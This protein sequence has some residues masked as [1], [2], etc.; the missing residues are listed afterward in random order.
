MD[1]LIA[2][3]LGIPIALI[4]GFYDRRRAPKP[5]ID[6]TKS[7]LRPAT[8]DAATPSQ[9]DVP[10]LTRLVDE[11]PA[12][13]RPV[14]QFVVKNEIS[15]LVSAKDLREKIASGTLMPN[16]PVWTEGAS[17]WKPASD[18]A[19]LAGGSFGEQSGKSSSVGFCMPTVL[20]GRAVRSQAAKDAYAAPIWQYKVN[21]KVS[22][23]FLSTDEIRS[24][25]ADGRLPPIVDV[26]TEGVKNWRPAPDYLVFAGIQRMRSD[27]LQD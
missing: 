22:S 7:L 15:S 14:W 4:I 8:Q 24:R 23:D 13:A 11:V 21:G 25:I 18:Y 6:P 20:V 2:L 12:D 19:I 5:S 17:K 16:V 1:A 26:W 9:S 27:Q 10:D 3:I